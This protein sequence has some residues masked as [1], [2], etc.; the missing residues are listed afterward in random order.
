MLPFS[1]TGPY[2]QPL[3]LLEPQSVDAQPIAL[4]RQGDDV[5]TPQ[6]ARV[7]D[8]GPAPAIARHDVEFV[9]ETREEIAFLEGFFD[10]RQGKAH[11]FWL[12]LWASWEFDVRGYEEPNGG[13]Y[14]LW[15]TRTGYVESFFP[16]GA[17]Y[18][19][20]LLLWGDRYKNFT[21]DA[22]V[23][24]DSPGID[25]VH[26]SGN[27]DASVATIPTDFFHVQ[28]RNDAYRPLWL[29]WGRFDQDELV[30]EELGEGAGRIALSFVELPAEAP[31]S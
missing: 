5:E 27:G 7:I 28:P 18:R 19:Q 14:F 6:G 25:R 3:L 29:R 11:G 2:S 8:A 30:T 9:L 23:A 22:A 26:L 1:L 4:G 17:A 10:A 16:L 12:P 24:N 21:I 15:V 31:T 13:S 20:L